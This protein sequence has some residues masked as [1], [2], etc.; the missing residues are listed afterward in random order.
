MHLNI[1]ALVHP[2]AVPEKYKPHYKSEEEFKDGLILDRKAM[3]FFYGTL[4][5][6]S[7]NEDQLTTQTPLNS[8]HI[9]SMQAPSCGQAMAKSILQPISRF[10]GKRAGTFSF[11]E[12]ICLHGYRMDLLR[13][14]GL[15]YESILREDGVPTR[16][17]VYKGLPHAAL[18]FMPMLSQ[19]KQA[20]KDL[21]PAFDWLLNQKSS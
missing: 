15:I 20:V 18:D 7:E 9:L 3:E 6:V 21:K 13:D 11:V 10:A 17:N 16:L 1:P 8:I 4:K 14:D 12:H 2:D 5:K 19:S